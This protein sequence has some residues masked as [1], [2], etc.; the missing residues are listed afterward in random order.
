[1][2]I[3][4]FYRNCYLYLYLPYCG[5]FC[6]SDGESFRYGKGLDNEK[7]RSVVSLMGLVMDLGLRRNDQGFS[8]RVHVVR[9][10]CQ[11]LSWNFGNL[12]CAVVSIGLP[13]GIPR[14][15][16]IVIR[17]TLSRH[18]PEQGFIGLARAAWRCSG[19]LGGVWSG[20]WAGSRELVISPCD[21][22]V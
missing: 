4:P 3:F 13:P 21:T 6:L 8:G 10:F 2:L 15:G 18:D 14:V 11:F 22:V 12:R 7:R 17:S 9:V 20:F 19:V 5:P 1:M 16:S